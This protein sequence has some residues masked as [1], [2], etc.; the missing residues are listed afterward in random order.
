MTNAIRVLG[1]ACSLILVSACS[2]IVDGHSQ[3]LTFESNPAGA[4]CTLTRHGEVIGKFT[5]PSQLTVTKT[6]YDIDVVCKKD[7][8]E[9]AT[10]HVKSDVAAAT[11]GNIIIGG[12]VGWFIDSATGADNKYQEVNVI[13]FTTASSTK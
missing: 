11:F 5:T 7:G 13:T 4:D 9:D 12:G 6:K 8:Y 1:A 10:D 2:S 3:K